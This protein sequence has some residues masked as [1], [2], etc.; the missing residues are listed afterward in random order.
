M[1]RQIA[2]L[3]TALH[4]AELDLEEPRDVDIKIFDTLFRWRYPNSDF[5]LQA[6]D[7]YITERGLKITHKR[8]TPLLTMYHI[9][10]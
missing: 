1:E 6:L 8:W 4:Q 9:R 2:E 5:G 7:L 10:K 3:Q